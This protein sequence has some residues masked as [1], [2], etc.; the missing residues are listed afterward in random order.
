M[1]YGEYEFTNSKVKKSFS[2]PDAPR[3]GEVMGIGWTIGE[4]ILYGTTTT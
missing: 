3:F 1:I 2:A 4:E